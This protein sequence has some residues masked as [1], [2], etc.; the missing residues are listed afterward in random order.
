[1][2]VGKEELVGLLAAVDFY[3]EG[4]EEE[5]RAR[6]EA[7]AA[8][9][10]ERLAV[11]PGLRARRQFPNFKLQPLP[12]VV[13]ELN[14]SRIGLSRDQLVQRLGAGVPRVE[15]ASHGPSAIILNPD[16]LRDG[17]AEIVVARVAEAVRAG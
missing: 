7:G 14:E 5:Q 12:E 9:L 11:V 16:T 6:C 8:L 13:V 1:M 2:K 4:G 17:D 10:L 15:V 3:L